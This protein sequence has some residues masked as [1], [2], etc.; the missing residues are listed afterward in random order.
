LFACAIFRACS[1]HAP[2]GFSEL[3]IFDVPP[4][5]VEN[6]GCNATTSQWKLLTRL[7]HL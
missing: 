3:P 6:A 1:L 4:E 5:E 2:A 7:L